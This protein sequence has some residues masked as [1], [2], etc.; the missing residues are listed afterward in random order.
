MAGSSFTSLTDVQREMNNLIQ[1]ISVDSF[2]I[3]VQNTLTAF[4]YQGLNVLSI[5][6]ELYSRGA[7]TNKTTAEV[8]GDVIA[9]ILLF[10]SRGNN[11]DKMLTR[12]NEEGRIKINN[13][14][15]VY[16][17]S[18]RVGGGGNEIITLSRVA[19]VFPVVTL[20]LLANPAFSIPRT[21]TLAPSEFGENFPGTMQTVIAAAVFPR[22]QVGISLMKALLLYL[23]EENKLLGGTSASSDQETLTE[24]IPFARASFVSSIVSQG[25][26]LKVCAALDLVIGN[27]ANPNLIVAINTFSGKFPGADLNFIN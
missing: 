15:L 2:A 9:M 22:G 27:N 14:K 19:V 3:T 17:L 20:K 12:T 4:E 25:D 5:V 16:R 18:N 1:A 11:I 24:V 8:Q 13:L 6:K 7:A 21:V 10:L 23:I 26:R